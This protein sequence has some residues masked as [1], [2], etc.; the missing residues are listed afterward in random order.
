MYE[1]L[2][3][4]VLLLGSNEFCRFSTAWNISP[5]RKGVSSRLYMSDPDGLIETMRRTL[6][7]KNDV[8]ELAESQSSN[9]PDL[10]L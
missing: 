8:S 4:I 2:L 7:D 5:R 10:K 3:L 1:L 9:G 6:G